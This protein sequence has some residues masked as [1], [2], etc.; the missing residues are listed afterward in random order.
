M[1][2]EHVEPIFDTEAAHSP[3]NYQSLGIRPKRKHHED[4]SDSDSSWTDEVEQYIKDILKKCE[5]SSSAHEKAGYEAKKL[6]AR[7]AFPGTLIP[8]ISAPVVGV[9]KDQEW[10]IYFTLA[11]MVSTAVCNGFSNFFNFG[12]KSQLHFNFAGR[13]ADIVT[14]IQECLA[15]T[16]NKRASGQVVMRTVKM[17]YDA[18]SL[19]APET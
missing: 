16:K 14:D 9:F 7:Y 19:S 13:Y 2:T 18:L 1:T 5:D 10:C 12:Q 17:K 15:K 3:P 6:H 8:T 11:S 4:G